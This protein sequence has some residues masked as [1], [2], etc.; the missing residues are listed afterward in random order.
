MRRVVVLVL[1]LCVCGLG[2]AACGGGKHS[3][4]RTPPPGRNV[5]PTPAEGVDSAIAR[6]E[7]A[8]TAGGCD[9]VKGLLH[10]SYGQVSDV[11]CRAVK[12]QIDGFRNPAAQR[13]G[14]GAVIDY[15]TFTGR[16]RAI[17]LVLDPDR[18][19]RLD[20]VIDVPDATIGTAKPA[21]FDRAAGEVVRAMQT[22]N[23]DA[24]LRLVDRAEG[25][26]VGS[27]REVCQRVSGVP[28]RRELVAN[29]SARPVPLGGNSQLAFYKL[30]TSPD[31]YY[32]MVM[33]QV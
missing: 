29:P 12:A 24:F 25:L 3:A 11:S 19:F 9:A 5:D 6:V 31:A 27:D 16:H 2:V 17:A 14:T 28:F 32:T 10:S 30:R 21:G 33:R 18:T 23:C 13:Y 15:T 22:G 8:V 4:K 20:F 7:G 1:A 26:G